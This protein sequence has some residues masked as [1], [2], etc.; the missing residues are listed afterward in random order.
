MNIIMEVKSIVV[1]ILLS[2]LLLSSNLVQASLALDNIHYIV[3]G[4]SGDV[5]GLTLKVDFILDYINDLNLEVTYREEELKLGTTWQ[6][7]FIQRHNYKLNLGLGLELE[8]QKMELAKTLSIG[9]EGTYLSNNNY[10]WEIK[11]DDSKNYLYN[12]GIALPVTKSSFLTI[13]VNN[14]YLDLS[15]IFLNLGLK[16]NL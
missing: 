4:I 13:G 8:P 9:G 15:N 11:Q 10:Y 2:V 16:V 12:L 1:I 6:I 7:N 5:Y 14:A 3:T